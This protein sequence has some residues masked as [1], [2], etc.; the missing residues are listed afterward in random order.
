MN[1]LHPNKKDE[2]LFVSVGCFVLN[3]KIAWRML[4]C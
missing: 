2:Q 1:T 4:P 3:V